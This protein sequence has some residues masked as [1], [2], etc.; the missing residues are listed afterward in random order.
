[1]DIS[2]Q[3]LMAYIGSAAIGYLIAMMSLNYG[4]VE[5][6]QFVLTM[7]DLLPIEKQGTYKM[8][9]RTH[10]YAAL[11]VGEEGSVFPDSYIRLERASEQSVI[12][13]EGDVAQYF[14]AE[15]NV[16]QD[17]S[18]IFVMAR[19]YQ[20]SGLTEIVTINKQSGTGFDTK[21]TGSHVSGLPTSD[22]YF[23]AC[24]EL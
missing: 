7:P 13:V 22:T 18:K 2:K 6:K 12:Y 15:Y 8:D 1:M 16:L 19:S 23:L 24:T 3:Q 20:P 11:V 17:D 14:G 5:G 4:S 9:C 21:T 10:E